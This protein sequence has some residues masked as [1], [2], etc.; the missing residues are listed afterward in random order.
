MVLGHQN[1][2]AVTAAIAN[3]DN[4][5]NLNHLLAHIDPAI[6]ASKANAPVKEIVLKNAILA[7]DE[8]V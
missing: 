4:G 7:A 2:G 6:K 5:P 3:E 1:C 8:L